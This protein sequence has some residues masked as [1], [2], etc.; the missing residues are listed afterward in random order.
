MSC[1]G[2]SP[3]KEPPY[4]FAGRRGG[5]I[6]VGHEPIVS[7]LNPAF[8]AGQADHAYLCLMRAHIPSMEG[9]EYPVQLAADASSPDHESRHARQGGN[10]TRRLRI[11][12]SQART[13]L[14]GQR[15]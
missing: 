4:D 10:F 11:V 15:E 1:I 8:S 7:R 14:L 2:C 9:P 12:A 13:T 3:K 6:H 5:P